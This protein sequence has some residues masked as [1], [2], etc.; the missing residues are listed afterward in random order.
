MKPE[1]YVPG[2]ECPCGIEGCTGSKLSFRTGH[3]ARVCACASC[4]GLRN[5]RKG[6]RGQART[7]RALGGTGFTPSN[8]ESG[9]PYTIEVSVLPEVKT[10]QQIPAS[11][12]RF[13][14]SEWFRR[15][16]SQSERSVPFGTGVLPAVVIRG[17]WCI[18]DIRK[19]GAA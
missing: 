8:E 16:L 13:A 3:V 11:W 15:A 10:G 17:D 14:A 7:H 5:Q 4:R 12:D 18:V 19:K 1:E 9:R 2:T 6:K